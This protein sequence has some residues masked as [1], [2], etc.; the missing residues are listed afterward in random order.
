MTDDRSGILL[1]GS[2]GFLGGEVLARLLERDE[3]SVYALVR[4]P[5]DDEA[6]AR[7]DAVIAALMGEAE[8][9]RGAVAVAADIARPELGMAA[10][11]RNWLAER[12]ELVI[13]CAAS[14][15]FSLGLPESRR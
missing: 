4:A 6:Q 1:T 7:L 2:T 8:P 10:A 13:H 9:R 12:V 11:T 15:S 14:V 5:G 3:R